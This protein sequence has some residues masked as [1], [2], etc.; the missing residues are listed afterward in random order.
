MRQAIT[1]QDNR[2]AGDFVVSYGMMLARIGGK[3][4]IVR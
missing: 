1:D 3:L 2:P 4:S